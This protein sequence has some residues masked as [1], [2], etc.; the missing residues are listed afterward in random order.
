MP[1][2]G[3]WNVIEDEAPDAPCGKHDNP[4]DGAY[5]TT[6]TRAVLAAGPPARSTLGLRTGPRLNPS[7][8]TEP[9]NRRPKDNRR[10]RL[11]MVSAQE[12]VGV[13]PASCSRRNQSALAMSGR[14]SIWS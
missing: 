13:S 3:Q 4:G 10:E 14:N 5:H 12:R 7:R 1:D 9:K 8:I 11:I 2:L 6:S